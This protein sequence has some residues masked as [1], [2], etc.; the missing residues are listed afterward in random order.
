M[1]VAEAEL[2]SAYTS[3]N[4]VTALI[5]GEEFMSDLHKADGGDLLHGAFPQ[6]V[7][8]WAAE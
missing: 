1:L 6:S 4:Q 7:P 8:Y 5:D 2:T 3:N